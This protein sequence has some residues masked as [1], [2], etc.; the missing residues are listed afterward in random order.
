MHACDCVCVFVVLAHQ[1]DIARAGLEREVDERFETMKKE[2][3]QL[4]GNLAQQAVQVENLSSKLC[5]V[6][7]TLEQLREMCTQLTADKDSLN[8]KNEELQHELLKQPKEV[9]CGTHI[10]PL[11]CCVQPSATPCALSKVRSSCYV[12]DVMIKMF[13]YL[14]GRDFQCGWQGELSA[15]GY[16][17]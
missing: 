7:Q 4:K 10:N 5:E 17:R 16:C 1:N 9:A 14:L 11:E 15:D 12:Y 2:T 13:H 6:G 3:E 8:K